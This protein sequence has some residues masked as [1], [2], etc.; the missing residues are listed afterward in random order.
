MCIS[1]PS[2]P[3]VAHNR[4]QAPS[5]GMYPNFAYFFFPCSPTDHPL[6]VARVFQSVLLSPPSKI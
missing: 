2:G 4:G 1:F 5:K 3:I 6:I